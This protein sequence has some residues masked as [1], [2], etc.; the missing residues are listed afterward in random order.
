MQENNIY[1]ALNQPRDEFLAG[2]KAE[3]PMMIGVIPF[4]MIY[5]ILALNAG[6][7]ASAA[8][9]MSAIIFAG[10]S[11]FVSA[12][13][14]SLSVPSVINVFTVGVINLRQAFYSASIS[15]S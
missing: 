6:L 3:L 14:F 10:S 15:P 1:D 7:P 4:G 9:T 13:L 2:V 8:Q 11:Q 12:Q 5:G